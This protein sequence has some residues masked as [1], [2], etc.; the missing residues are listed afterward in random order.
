ML[1]SCNC[2]LP[3]PVL[4]IWYL[5]YSGLDFL[6]LN[7]CYGETHRKSFITAHD[8][9]VVFQNYLVPLGFLKTL[10]LVKL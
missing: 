3:L 4:A 5:A 7:N 9:Y 2:L 10:I 6:Y 1:T 8:G